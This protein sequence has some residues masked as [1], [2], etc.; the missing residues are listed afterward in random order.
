MKDL[1]LLSCD[2]RSLLSLSFIQW[3]GLWLRRLIF[4]DRM[5][6]IIGIL[7]SLLVQFFFYQLHI[8]AHTLRTP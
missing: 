4:S 6:I 8:V 7:F 1:Y 3:V 5:M 2:C